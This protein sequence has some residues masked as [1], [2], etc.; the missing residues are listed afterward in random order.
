MFLRI[1]GRD[2]RVSDPQRA[3]RRRPAETRMTIRSYRT[4]PLGCGHSFALAIL[5]GSNPS[6]RS[7]T[8]LVTPAALLAQTSKSLA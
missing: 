1:P 8:F 5:E 3:A 4:N 6:A 7:T 2:Q